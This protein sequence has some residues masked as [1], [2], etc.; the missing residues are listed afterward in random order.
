MNIGEQIK[1]MRKRRHITQEQLAQATGIHPVTIRKYEINKLQPKK[2]QIDRI[3]KALSVSPLAFGEF[4][5]NMLRLE[6]VGDLMGLMIMLYKSGVIGITGRKEK[7]G[8]I[9]PESATITASPLFDKHFFVEGKR[10]KP[11]VTGISFQMMDQTLLGD[12]VK[13][14]NL[15]NNH[16]KLV[17]KYADTKSDVEREYMQGNEDQ[18][19]ALELELMSFSEPL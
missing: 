17:K 6:T 4:D 2:E 5:S 14:A 11:S 18:M 16:K 7:G 3:A 13:W 12:F 8:G 9:K 10:G 1:Y 15:Y 19:A